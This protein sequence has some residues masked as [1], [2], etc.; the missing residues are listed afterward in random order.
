M[1]APLIHWTQEPYCFNCNNDANDPDSRSDAKGG[2]P[3]A[4]EV[5]T[6]GDSTYAVV[7]LERQGSLV[8]FEVRGGSKVVLIRTSVKGGSG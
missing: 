1:P 4:I 6:E 5:F 8:V 7:G 3:E 2:E